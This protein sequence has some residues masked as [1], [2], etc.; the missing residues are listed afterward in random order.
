MSTILWFKTSSDQFCAHFEAWDILTCFTFSSC[1]FI[2]GGVKANFTKIVKF[3]SESAYYIFILHVTVQ[4]RIQRDNRF[5]RI[6]HSYSTSQKDLEPWTWGRNTTYAFSICLL[7]ALI[8]I[9]FKALLHNIIP[10][11]RKENVR[12][13]HPSSICLFLPGFW[14][15]ELREGIFLISF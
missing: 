3:Y 4:N 1:I 9:L 2:H 7:K 15:L 12:L 14:P 8:Y 10:Y 5:I 11:L 13:S 6:W